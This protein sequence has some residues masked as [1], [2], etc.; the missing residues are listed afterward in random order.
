MSDV[1]SADCAASSRWTGG[2]LRSRGIR[3]EPRGGEPH[4]ERTQADPKDLECPARD[5]EQVTRF[6]LFVT[7]SHGLSLAVTLGL[8]SATSLPALDSLSLPYC[9]VAPV[10]SLS[11]WSVFACMV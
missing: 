4:R 2:P 9:A 1:G 10:L 8:V 11:G 7:V 3:R 5:P 6:A